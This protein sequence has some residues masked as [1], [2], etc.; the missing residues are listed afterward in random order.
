LEDGDVLGEAV[1]G[2]ADEGLAF[3]FGAF[4]GVDVV[5]VGLGELSEALVHVCDVED[6]VT[7]GDEAVGGEEV[8]EGEAVVLGL[9]CLDSELELKFCFVGVSIR[10]AGGWREGA[11]KGAQ[12]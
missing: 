2:G 9:V 4:E 11:R 1:E 8:F 10:E 12:Q 7:V 6:D 3:G 5:A